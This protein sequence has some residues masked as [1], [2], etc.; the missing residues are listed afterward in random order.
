MIMSHTF[1]LFSIIAENSCCLLRQRSS[2]SWTYRGIWISSR[3]VSHRLD[4]LSRRAGGRV[5]IAPGS[6]G[7]IVCVRVERQKTGRVDAESRV[8][9]RSGTNRFRFR[10]ARAPTGS[11]ET[12]YFEK[13][14]ERSLAVTGHLLH[15]IKWR[16]WRLL[17]GAWHLARVHA[18]THY[19]RCRSTF[20]LFSASF[21]SRSPPANFLIAKTESEA[22]LSIFH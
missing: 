18:D 15:P 10:N 1:P 13:G 4:S 11:Q 16:N 22:G 12:Y 3:Q 8:P 21:G 17:F 20:F 9:R 5:N 2:I 14:A 7:W 19:F 6:P